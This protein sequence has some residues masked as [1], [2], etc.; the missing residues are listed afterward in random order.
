[1][2]QKNL[3]LIYDEGCPLCVCY[4]SLFVKLGFLQKEERTSFTEAA[5]ALLT[6]IDFGRSKNEI[7][8]VDTTTGQVLYGIDSLL[9]ILNRKIPFIKTI[10][11]IHPVKWFLQRLY[12]FISY[13]R[14]LIVAKKTAYECVDCTPDFNWF[15]R[16]FFMVFFLVFNTIMLLPIHTSILS[17]LPFY[18]LSLLQMQ[19]L[20]FGLVTVNVSVS[21]F[22]GSKKGIDYLGQVNMLALS[23]VLLTLPLLLLC[24]MITASPLLIT[25]YLTVISLVIL[26]DYRRRMKFADLTGNKW[27]I[28]TNLLSFALFLLV[29]F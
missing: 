1:M 26:A 27:L 25:L 9:E 20:H 19:L 17:K 5:N 10:G 16:I 12:K 28:V 24:N 2:K 6:K 13:N 4:T 7:P 23:T 14:K 3:V 11:N 22:L 29:L 8:L 21:F 18:H 15:Y